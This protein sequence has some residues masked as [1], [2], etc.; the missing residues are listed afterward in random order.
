VTEHRVIVSRRALADALCIKRRIRQAGAPRTAHAWLDRLLS[1]MRGLG[2]MPRRGRRLQAALGG[3]HELRQ[4]VFGRY[5]VI[6]VVRRDEVVVL[7]IRHSG[8]RALRRTDL[9]E[10]L[11]ELE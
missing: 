11:G 6:Y 10:A 1:T 5:R 7:T 8:R 2:S 9:A 4:V 3:A